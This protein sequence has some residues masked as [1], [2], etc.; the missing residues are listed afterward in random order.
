MVLRPGPHSLILA[1]P[2]I[3][4]TLWIGFGS[5]ALVTSGGSPG[6]GL[7]VFGIALAFSVL[8]LPFVLYFLRTRLVVHADE[9][10][11]HA[12]LGFRVKRMSRHA[13]ARVKVTR[14]N[15]VGSD[16]QW[17][18]P[19]SRYTIIGRDGRRWAVFSSWFWRLS[20]CER[21]REELL[22]PGSH[23]GLAP[24]PGATRQAHRPEAGAA[25][26]GFQS[27]LQSAGCVVQG[28]STVFGFG[29]A[30]VLAAAAFKIPMG[31]ELGAASVPG[32]LV[33][34]AIGSAALLSRQIY[35]MLKDQNTRPLVAK[36]VAV[37]WTLAIPVVIWAA[38]LFVVSALLT[39][40]GRTSG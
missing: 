13:V 29:L 32:A 24:A 22:H 23:A 28:C 10:E 6:V 5:I 37:A 35:A 2:G 4:I 9:L 31:R 36:L 26:E 8:W 1:I 20:D 15:A 19:V 39:V 12:L 27:F 3:L 17:M 21:L 40:L 25:G 30:M 18:I 14:G 34:T 7:G 11:L 16:D 33:G 38:A